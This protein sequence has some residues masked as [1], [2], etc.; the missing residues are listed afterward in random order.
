[1]LNIVLNTQDD[2]QVLN[3]NGYI[4][5]AGSP[6][7]ITSVDQLIFELN[8][9]LPYVAFYPD[10]S[11]YGE[12]VLKENIL[13]ITLKDV[14]YPRKGIIYFG[15]SKTAACIGIICGYKTVTGFYSAMKYPIEVIASQ[16]KEDAMALLSAGTRF[17]IIHELLT[18]LST[19][20]VYP[21]TTV[22]IYP[23][24]YVKYLLS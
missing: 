9:Q 20:R 21:I 2:T 17:V 4:L 24:S 5:R 18:D 10:T 6:L 13:S 23:S 19:P 22:K 3:R 15:S 12:S 7:D 1:M 8:T 14:D 16:T 11:E